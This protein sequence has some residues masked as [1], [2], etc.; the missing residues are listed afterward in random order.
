M[1]STLLKYLKQP[2]TWR[3]IIGIAT[4]LGIGIS[5]DLAVEIVAAGLGLTGVIN[6]VRNEKKT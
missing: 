4:T 2:S 3:G 6:V 1:F 5:P